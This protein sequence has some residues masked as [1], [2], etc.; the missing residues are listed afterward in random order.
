MDNI[1]TVLA[2]PR[3]R[4]TGDIWATTLIRATAHVC[5]ALK[6]ELFTE[7]QPRCSDRET[8]VVDNLSHDRCEGMTGQE[9]QCYLEEPMDGFPAPLLAWMRQPRVDYSLGPLLVAW[10]HSHFPELL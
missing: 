8:V 7:W 2:W 6:V 3:G 9:V 5:A 4:S 10:L 1:A